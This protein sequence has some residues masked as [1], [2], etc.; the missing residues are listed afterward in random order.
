M[1]KVSPPPSD[2]FVKVYEGLPVLLEPTSFCVECEVLLHLGDI[3]HLLPREPL[4]LG[5]VD[6]RPIHRDERA[7]GKVEAF[8]RPKVVY[9]GRGEVHEVGN[10]LVVPYDAVCL[11]ATLLLA[12]FRVAPCPLQ[13]GRADTARCLPR[14]FK[15]SHSFIGHQ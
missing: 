4:H 15:L 8:Q 2:F 5:I 9:G 11:D 13:N 3:A 6:V 10:P 12:V 7:C 1:R 14:F